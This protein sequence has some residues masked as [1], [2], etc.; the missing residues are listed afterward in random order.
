MLSK[1]D[2]VTVVLV[3]DLNNSPWIR[4]ASHYSS[5][6]G[7]DLVGRPNNSER[8]L[9]H[10]L[11]GC[12]SG[13]LIVVVVFW[14]VEQLDSL[15]IYVV[16]NSL[17]ELLDLLL[18]ESVG[19]GNHWNKVYLF[20]NL[21]HESDV[22]RLQR[23][24]GRL[25]K[26]QAC[27]DSVVDNGGPVDLGLSLQVLVESGVDLVDNR[28]PG[29]SI[30]DTLAESWTVNNGQAQLDVVF[31]DIGADSLDGNLNWFFWIRERCFRERVHWVQILVEKS[32]Y[33]SRLTQTS[34]TNNQQVQAEASSDRFSVP[35]FWQVSESNVSVQLA[36]D[37]FDFTL[38]HCGFGG[39]LFDLFGLLR[40][41]DGLFWF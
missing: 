11:S 23:V 28:F 34:L 4:S 7:L 6:W 8:C 12:S 29:I 13:L 25:N 27:V 22:Q 38:W 1:L 17:L 20:V 30:V 35:L 14:R 18:G 10:D 31:L 3:V 41:N 37:D 33:Q 2:E 21:L 19:F 5:V 9:G 24:S 26:V 32:V 16:Q 15:V 36:A 39:W 40:R